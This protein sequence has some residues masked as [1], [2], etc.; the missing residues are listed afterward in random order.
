MKCS[1]LS[2]RQAEVAAYVARGLTDKE[3]AN[4]LGLSRRTVENHIRAAA[5][6]IPGSS[7][8]RHRITIWYFSLSSDTTTD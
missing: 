6:A 8:P 5:Q 2:R 3:I 7:Y 4:R 1:G